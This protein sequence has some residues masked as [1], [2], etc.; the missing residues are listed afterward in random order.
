MM[1]RDKLI[2]AGRAFC[3]FFFNVSDVLIYK[4]LPMP[5]LNDELVGEFSTSSG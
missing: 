5:C 1:E 4:D 2:H 3:V